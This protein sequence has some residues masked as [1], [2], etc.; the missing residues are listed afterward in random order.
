TNPPLGFAGG[1]GGGHSKPPV[2]SSLNT[3]SFLLFNTAFFFILRH[4][5]P[6]QIFHFFFSTKKFINIG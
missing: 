6:Q 2:I 1:L 4:P 5:Y 3:F